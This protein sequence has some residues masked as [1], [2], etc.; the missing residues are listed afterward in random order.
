[1]RS[2]FLRSRAPGL[3]YPIRRVGDTASAALN[4]W[5]GCFNLEHN[6]KDVYSSMGCG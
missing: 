4:N 1:M 2:H 6:E 5:Y 3:L